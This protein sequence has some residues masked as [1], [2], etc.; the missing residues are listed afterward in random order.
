MRLEQK[1][2][3]VVFTGM[4]LATMLFPGPVYELSF[5]KDFRGGVMT[6]FSKL[7][8]QCFGS[9]AALCGLTALSTRWTSTSFRNFGLAMIPYFVFD[10]YFHY[11]GAITTLGAVGDGIG[12][13]IFSYCC[14]VGYHNCKMEEN[15]KDES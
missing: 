6:P 12:N 8:I 2:L 10:A 3:G 7:I 9:Q 14:W 15:E 4:G 1:V 13:I 5:T 11:T